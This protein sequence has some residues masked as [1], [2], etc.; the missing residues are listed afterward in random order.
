[1]PGARRASHRFAAGMAFAMLGGVTPFRGERKEGGIKDHCLL[2]S[3]PV[4]TAETGVLFHG[5]WVHLS[6]Y[7]HE[8][9]STD[10]TQ[11]DTAEAPE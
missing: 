2:C 7:E 11:A 1:M 3:A 10:S 8:N 6:C 5:L 9:Q 4:Y